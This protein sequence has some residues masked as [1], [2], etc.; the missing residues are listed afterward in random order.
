M[1]ISSALSFTLIPIIAAIFGAAVAVVKRPSSIVASAIQHFAAGVVFAAAAGEVLPNL[2]HGSSLWPII[3]G[4]GFGI[5]LMLVIQNLGE[6]T[7]GPTGLIALVGVDV[8]IDGLVLG[9]GFAASPKVGLLLTIALTLEVL[10]LGLSLATELLD[11]AYT[12]ARV[13]GLVAAV[14]LLLPVGV[15]AANIVAH[16]SPAALQGFFAFGLISLLYLVTE[17]L[18]IEAHETR[19]LPWVTSLFF[20]GFL[21]LLILEEGMS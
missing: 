20:I 1:A 3:I 6:Q 8:F 10:F 11:A 16:L 19:D 13:V 17:E 18:L 21:L 5:V 9:L 14:A 15:S 7:K 2:K 12:R 4:G